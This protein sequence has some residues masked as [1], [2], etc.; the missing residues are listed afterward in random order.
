MANVPKTQQDCIRAVQKKW[1]KKKIRRTHKMGV[2]KEKKQRKERRK[3]KRTQSIRCNFQ[4]KYQQNLMCNHYYSTFISFFRSCSTWLASMIFT[5]QN[6]SSYSY[7]APFYTT[8]STTTVSV[9]FTDTSTTTV[10]PDSLHLHTHFDLLE[11]ANKILLASC[12][13]NAFVVLKRL[14][15]HTHTHHVEPRDEIK[16]RA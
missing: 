15:I 9:I 10:N 14:W 5:P 4:S 8:T 2:W 3:A 12:L 1:R 13:L 6:L 11:A 7:I 16:Y